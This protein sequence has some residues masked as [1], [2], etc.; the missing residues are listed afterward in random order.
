MP[1]YSNTD[2]CRAIAEY[3]HDKKYREILRLR[4]C[5]GHTYEEIAEICNYSP[6]HVKNI[7]RTYKSVLM[8]RL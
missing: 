6:Q 3:C 2:M 8:S 5:E 4:F 7:C 1:I